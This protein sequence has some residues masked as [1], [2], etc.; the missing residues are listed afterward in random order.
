[1]SVDGTLSRRGPGG[2]HG[3]GAFLLSVRPGGVVTTRSR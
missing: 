3:G 2:S 1:M